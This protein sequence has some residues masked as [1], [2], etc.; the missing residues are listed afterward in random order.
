MQ[1]H[2]NHLQA[3]HRLTATEWPHLFLSHCIIIADEDRSRDCISHVLQTTGYL[4]IGSHAAVVNVV[5]VVKLL[6]MLSC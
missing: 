5:N 2:L 6:I 4:F 3:T 1:P